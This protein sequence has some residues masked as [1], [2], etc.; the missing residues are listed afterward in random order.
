MQQ[1]DYMQQD[2]LRFI[3]ELHQDDQKYLVLLNGL[4][5]IITKMELLYYPQLHSPLRMLTTKDIFYVKPLA[6]FHL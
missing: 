4:N 1:P 2:P 5:G 3:N 6:M